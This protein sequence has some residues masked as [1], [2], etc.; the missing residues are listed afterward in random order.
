MKFP[1]YDLTVNSNTWW[2]F[3]KMWGPDEVANYICSWVSP[4]GAKAENGDEIVL[5]KFGTFTIISIS[6]NVIV[7]YNIQWY[8]YNLSSPTGEKNKGHREPAPTIQPCSMDGLWTENTISFYSCPKAN[9]TIVV[10]Y[11]L[12]INRP[13]ASTYLV[14]TKCLTYRQ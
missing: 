1:K 9:L 8:P 5:P 14:A 11:L 2:T 13:H 7:S 3:L 12:T 4:S 10:N 6:R